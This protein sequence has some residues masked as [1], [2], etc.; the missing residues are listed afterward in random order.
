MVSMGIHEAW[1]SVYIPQLLKNNKVVTITKDEATWI[2]SI[3]F[4]GTLIGCCVSLT[5][6]DKFGR[7]VTILLTTIPFSLSFLTL[8]YVRT[9][10]SFCVIRSLAGVASGLSVVVLPLY[11]AEIADPKIR[12]TLGT[13]IYVFNLLGFLVINVVGSIFSIFTSSL[14]SL[15]LPILVVLTFSWMPESPYY[16]IMKS[17]YR[18]AKRA[19]IKFK[20]TC[21]VEDD[22]KR[23]HDAVKIDSESKGKLCELFTKKTNR[24]ALFIQFILL[25]GKQF[26]GDDLYD[27]YAQTI[28]GQFLHTL[29]PSTVVA[30]FYTVKLLMTIFSTFLIDKIGRKPILLFSFVISGIL[31]LLLGLFLYLDKHSILENTYFD[32]LAATLLIVFAVSYSFIAPV[33]MIVVGELFPMNVKVF[34]S[35]FCE[36]YF[37]ILSIVVIYFYELTSKYFG[38]AVPFI[39]FGISSFVHFVLIYLFLIETKGITLEEILNKLNQSAF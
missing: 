15:S 11:I 23:L 2:T 39:I 21:D 32:Y 3:F 22:I 17:N 9:F 18:E 34:A 5:I 16:L 27:V 30:I 24:R 37:C 14:L 33:P 25:N 13:F 35:I 20:G 1:T 26:T 19:L 6:T 29:T 7:K 28:F 4:I 12:G 36:I 8:P 38:I 10:W 31:L